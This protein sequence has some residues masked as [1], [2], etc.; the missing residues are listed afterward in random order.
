[1][2]NNKLE[3]IRELINNLKES[4]LYAM[5]LS[6]MELFHTNFWQ[7]LMRF[8]NRYVSIFFDDINVKSI[9]KKNI[10]R[11]YKN[12]DISIEYDN[13]LY[14]IENK[15]KSL[16]NREQ[17]EKY[18]NN[19]SFIK[20]VYI[21]PF[22]HESFNEICNNWNFKS[23]NEIIENICE[24]TKKIEINEKNN[25]NIVIIKEYINMTKTLIKLFENV[26]DYIG[27]NYINFINNKELIYL[28]KEI[29]I[30]DIILKIN[31][32]LISI[33]LLK[34]L[35][36][37]FNDEELKKIKIQNSYNNGSSTISARWN[38][39][40]NDFENG[41]FLI[42]PQLEKDGF[43]TMIHITTESFGIKNIKTERQGVLDSLYESIEKDVFG[44]INYEYPRTSRKY[45]KY[46]AIFDNK[47][48]IAM[49]K[50][51]QIK[52]SS[53]EY[54][55]DLFI[56]ELDRLKNINSKNLYTRIKEGLAMYN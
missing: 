27:N 24:I 55:C 52:D 54:I 10:R 15:M 5:S 31:G 45:D 39:L 44:E 28:L 22:Y 42:G 16:P 46:R 12:T 32:H 21:F 20:G 33:E 8:D 1:M 48:Y 47:Q 9:N 13:K 34:R 49:Y 6:S 18:S 50:Y 11:E 19:N 29:R 23:Y 53:F 56:N 51:N 7:W 14:I 3:V 41:Y 17:L 30:D 26:I 43:R 2:K 40:Y 4:A 36:E 37:K 25:S 35:K 38:L